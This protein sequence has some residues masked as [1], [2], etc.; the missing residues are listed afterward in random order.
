MAPILDL[1][2]GVSKG[3]AGATP[4]AV[5]GV[6][7]KNLGAAS[8]QW[9]GLGA[10][11]EPLRLIAWLCAAYVAGAVL[12]SWADFAGYLLAPWIRVPAIAEMRMAVSRHLLTLSLRFFPGQ[13]TGELVSRLDLD[14]RSAAA[15]LETIV[16]T[17][18][19]APV[20]MAFYAWLLVRTS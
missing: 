15:G 20:L 18:L 13:R 19:S 2:L 12:K 17:V 3:P 6:S 8:L 11:A 14:T 5:T 10:A 9:L 7:L 1:A 16:G 4:V